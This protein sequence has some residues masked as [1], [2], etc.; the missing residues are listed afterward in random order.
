MEPSVRLRT[1]LQGDTWQ[2]QWR[3]GVFNDDGSLDLVVSNQCGSAGFCDGG[4]VSIL[5]GNGDG[6]FRAGA[7][8]L[9]GGAYAFAVRVADFNQDGKTDLAVA[10]L[11][12]KV[13]CGGTLTGTVRVLLGNG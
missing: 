2:T 10:N 4:D 5:L 8:Y 1:T 11:C 9:P 13:N 3:W 7:T 6:T 12:D